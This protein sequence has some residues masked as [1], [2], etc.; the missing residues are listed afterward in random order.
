MFQP[1]QYYNILC[2]AE[3]MFLLKTELFEELLR[4][5]FDAR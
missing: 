2:D 3:Y 5:L 4:V 1:I